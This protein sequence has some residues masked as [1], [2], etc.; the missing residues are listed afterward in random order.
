MYSPEEKL[1]VCDRDYWWSDDWD[2]LDYGTNYDFSKTFFK[3]F[4][5]L[6]F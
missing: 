3:Q 6:Q 4:H 5:E 2:P 1:F